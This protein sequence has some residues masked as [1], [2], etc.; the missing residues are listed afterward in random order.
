MKICINAKK[1]APLHSQVSH[2]SV[3]QWIEWQ[4]PVLLIWVRFPSG[5]LWLGRSFLLLF[6]CT[7]LSVCKKSI[8]SSSP[9]LLKIDDPISFYP[10]CELLSLNDLSVFLNQFTQFVS[11]VP[12]HLSGGIGKCTLMVWSIVWKKYVH[13]FRSHSFI[14]D[15]WDATIA[16]ILLSGNPIAY[17]RITIVSPRFHC[18]AYP[19]LAYSS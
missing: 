12:N 13:P 6:Y 17:F 7:P 8:S 9:I 1:I 19:I 4:I 16:F 15:K 18:D 2:A 10:R 3:V 5:V 11:I 14:N